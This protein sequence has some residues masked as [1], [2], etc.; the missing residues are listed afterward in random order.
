M[1]RHSRIDYIFVPKAIVQAVQDSS[2][3]SCPAPDHKALSLTL[4]FNM[5]KR[6]TG[7]WKLNNSLLEDESYKTIIRSDIS[8]VIDTYGPLI[9]KQEL[10]ELIKVIVKESS[11]NY[12]TCRRS[13]KLCKMSQIENQLDSMDTN[14]S[15]LDNPVLWAKRMFL[16]KEL[17][18]LYQED[19]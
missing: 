14:I 11:I 1:S 12:S 13:K 9:S 6:G 16:K 2:V 4:S 10:I 15:R 3:L 7:Y 5:N 19:T 18:S 17:S 8:Q